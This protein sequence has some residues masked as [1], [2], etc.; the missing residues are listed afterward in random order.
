MFRAQVVLLVG[1]GLLLGSFL[2][3]LHPKVEIVRDRNLYHEAY[4]Q[5]PEYLNNT[6]Y[7]IGSN[8]F[9]ADVTT[10]RIME[11]FPYVA[12][13][14]EPIEKN[15]LQMWKVGP[16]D[17]DFPYRPEFESWTEMNPGYNH[18]HYT[19]AKLNEYVLSMFN[20]TVPEVAETL[21]QFPKL[22]LQSDFTRYVWIFLNG[23]V[24][25]DLDTECIYPIDNWPDAHD[26]SIHAVIAMESDN[27]IPEWDEMNTG[28]LQFENWGFKFKK[29]H[30]ALA[31]T[32]ANVVKLTF[33]LQ[34]CRKFE[35]KFKHMGLDSCHPLGVIEWTGPGVFTQSMVD[36]FNKG[37]KLEIRDFDFYRT[38]KVIFGPETDDF[39]SYKTF[40]GIESP[41]ILNDVCVLPPRGFQCQD[42]M[43]GKYCYLKHKFYGGWKSE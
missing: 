20:E 42:E 25:A 33:N 6:P 36:F 23:G 27:N 19:N 7:S 32:I 41:L 26:R 4:L 9:D 14:S 34:A 29:H 22:I 10:R 3:L 28:R 15:I 38:K 12:N 37:E 31:R 40:T 24:Y 21:K 35:D 18:V 8:P 43:I 30:P 39:V 11:A 5:S 2:T 16:D 1:A 17:P 13:Y